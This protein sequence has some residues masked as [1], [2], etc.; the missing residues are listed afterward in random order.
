M[1]ISSKN[2]FLLEELL[3]PE[4]CTWLWDIF[5]GPSCISNV[6]CLLMFVHFMHRVMRDFLND[7]DHDKPA[8]NENLGDSHTRVGKASGLD[9]VVQRKLNLGQH[10][11]KTRGQDNAASETRDARDDHFAGRS[12]GLRIRGRSR[13]LNASLDEIG[14]ESARQGN[15]G[16]KNQ[17]DNLGREGIH[18]EK[19]DGRVSIGD[20]KRT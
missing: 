10:V 17:G 14:K 18:L 15:Y 16:E 11:R 3:H 13:R 12:F 4:K 5:F 7:V 20:D 9:I 2:D 19:S 6:L 8:K 1:K